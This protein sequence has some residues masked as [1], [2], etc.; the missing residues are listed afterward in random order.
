MWVFIGAGQDCVHAFFLR[1]IAFYTGFLSLTSSYAFI[2]VQM[3]KMQQTSVKSDARF[4][5]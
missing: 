2:Q 4:S 1:F 5:M 3:V